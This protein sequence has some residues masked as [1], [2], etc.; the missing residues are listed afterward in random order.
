MLQSATLHRLQIFDSSELRGPLVARCSFLQQLV[1]LRGPS[2]HRVAGA[3]NSLEGDQET[4]P[5]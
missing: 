5:C 1:H 2:L 4:G 3:Q